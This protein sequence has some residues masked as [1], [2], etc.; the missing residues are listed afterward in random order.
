MVLTARV[1]IDLG[2]L[3][4]EHSLPLLRLDRFTR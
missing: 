1:M 2:R 3:L 4:I